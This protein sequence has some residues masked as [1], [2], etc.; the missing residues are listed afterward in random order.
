MRIPIR[1]Q[2]LV[3]LQVKEN[4]YRNAA[5]NVL[6]NLSTD[7]IIGENIFQV[8]EKVIFKFDGDKPPLT[9]NT[10]SQ[11]IVPDS[12]L[13]SHLDKNCWPIADKPRKYSKDNAEFIHDET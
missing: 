10:L 13:F 9:L 7:V 3:N 12:S 1:G 2:C 6:N 4:R 11:M 5:F 8:H